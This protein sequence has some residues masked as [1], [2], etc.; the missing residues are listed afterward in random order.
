MM[1]TGGRGLG[2]HLIGPVN[3]R[4]L[5]KDGSE[6]FEVSGTG[7]YGLLAEPVLCTRDLLRKVPPASS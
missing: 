1:E 3:Q 5:P 2:M 4:W 7:K 6:M